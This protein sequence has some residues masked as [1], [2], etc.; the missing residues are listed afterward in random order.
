[1]DHDVFSNDDIAGHVYFNLNNVCGLREV[2]E[3]GFSNVPQQTRNIF[4]P[5]PGGRYFE[6]KD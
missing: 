4:H 1:M 6:G 3:G 2:V 5:K